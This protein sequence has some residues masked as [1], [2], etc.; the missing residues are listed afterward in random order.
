M[1]TLVLHSHAVFVSVHR[2]K[3]KVDD[4]PNRL[5]LEYPAK[6]LPF[7]SILVH[8]AGGSV[9]FEAV[10]FLSVHNVPIVHMDW[11][12][13]LIASTLP[14][15]PIAGKL[16]VAQVQAYLSVEKR[17]SV[18]YALVG[19]KIAKTLDLLRFWKRYYPAIDL[20]AVE[21]EAKALRALK[22]TRD[23]RGGLMNVEGRVA[24]AYWNEFGKVVRECAPQLPFIGRRVPGISGSYGAT[25]GVNSALN[26]GYGFLEA[27]CRVAIATTGLDWNL[28]F[29]HEAQDNATPLVY[30]L[31][32][33]F[34]WLIDL[35]LIEVL[36]SGELSPRDFTTLPDYKVR[37]RP[38]GAK[39][40]V[41]RISENFNRS[42]AAKS[43]PRRYQTLLLENARRLERFIAGTNKR[44][45][46][47]NRFEAE[48]GAATAEV[49]AHLLVMSVEERKA[50]GLSKTTAFYHRRA[51]QA[52][53]PLRLY[54]KVREKM[55]AR[56]LAG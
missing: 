19:E 29:L 38:E 6:Q 9:S 56:V 47:S 23:L 2:W 5:H 35:S 28:G 37:L 8:N 32:E 51:I 1:K 16:R 24:Q 46:F 11:D 42:V 17:W 54:A 53:R 15:G 52:G 45:D 49:R 3:L 25:D 31:E 12:G 36:R 41:K 18:A 13:R 10:R 22:P 40:L 20:F 4:Y 39:A 48:N 50:L 14:P 43:G 33:L 7:D 44:L 27:Q 55:E 30:D 34:R 26:Y 21:K